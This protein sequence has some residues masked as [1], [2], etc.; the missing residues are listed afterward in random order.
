M[1]LKPYHARIRPGGHKFSTNIT[2]YHILGPFNPIGK[3]DTVR[4]FKKS[5]PRLTNTG[6]PGPNFERFPYPLMCSYQ[7]ETVQTVSY[8]CLALVQLMENSLSYRCFTNGNQVR[9][10][11]SFW[12]LKKSFK[13]RTHPLDPLP[14][15]E[16]Y[17]RFI[18]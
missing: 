10:F 4:R 18:N 13:K 14:P 15:S 9:I 12:F 1:Q 17:V 2:I 3:N 6:L 8:I 7:H 5:T 16:R 11:L